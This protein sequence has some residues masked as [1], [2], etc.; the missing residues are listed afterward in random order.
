MPQ[1]IRIEGRT[2]GTLLC[3]NTNNQTRC[4]ATCRQV[5]KYFQIASDDLPQPNKF[6]I[7][8]LTLAHWNNFKNS[9]CDNDG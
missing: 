6:I 8:E 7:A 5:R 2:D 4:R 3:I 9:V 1:N